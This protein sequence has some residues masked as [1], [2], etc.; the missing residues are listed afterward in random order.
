MRL[1]S[2]NDLIFNLEAI[3]AKKSQNPLLMVFLSV[4]VFSL[5]VNDLVTMVDFFLYWGNFF[6]N[7]PEHV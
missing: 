2:G 7:L 4:T 6:N 3:V 1:D 5:M